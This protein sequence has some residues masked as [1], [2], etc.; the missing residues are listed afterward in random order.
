MR[1]LLFEPRRRSRFLSRACGIGMT[2]N[3]AQLGI[4]SFK[5]RVS[6]LVSNFDFRLPPIGNRQSTTVWK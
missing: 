5:S 4:A 1:N 3:V 6:K 2:G